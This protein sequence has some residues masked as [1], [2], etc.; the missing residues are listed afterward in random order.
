MA[1]LVICTHS[2]LAEGFLNAAKM[3]VPTVSDI[4]AVCFENSCS[5]DTLVG[6]LDVAVDEFRNESNKY[7]IVTDM[8]GASP[9]N[10]ALQVAVKD[11]AYVI[12]GINL[13]L[14]LELAMLER[15]FDEAKL[16]EIVAMAENS[17]KM[18]DSKILRT[19]R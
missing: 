2:N 18:I 8:A 5:I 3:I 4:K 15:D 16:K 14:L 13:P 12:G 19:S 1:N 11:G 7:L 17:V 10:A 6:R 9:F